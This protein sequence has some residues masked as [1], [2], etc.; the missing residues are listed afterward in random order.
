MARPFTALRDERGFTLVEVMVALFILLVGVAGSVTLID[1]ANGTTLATKAREAGTGLTREVV[2]DARSIPYSSLS[3]ASIQPSLQAQPGLAD[4]NTG[5]SSWTVE[6]RGIVYTVQVS[7][8]AIDDGADGYGDHAD[9]SRYCP[10]GAASASADASADDYKRVLTTVS[11]TVR[12]RTR[13][14]R[15]TTLIPNPSAANGPKITAYSRNPN[16]DPLTDD[17]QQ[18]ISFTVTTDATAAGINWTVDGASAGSYAPTAQTSTFDWTIRDDVAGDYVVDGTYVVGATALDGQGAVGTT[19]SLTIRL[20]RRV[21]AA[22]TGLVGGWNA[23]RSS[24]DLDWRENDESDI[25]GYRVYRR[26]GSGTPAEVCATG[27]TLTTCSDSSPPADL[28]VDYWVVAL[29]ADP[30]TGAGREGGA[31][32]VKTVT[33]TTDRPNAPT[34]LI[35]AAVPSVGTDLVWTPPLPR[36]PSYAGDAILFYRIYRDGTALSA[37]YGRTGAGTDLSFTDTKVSSTARQYWVTAVDSNYSESAAVGPVS[38][39]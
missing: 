10:S 31:S 11:W 9:T 13:S 33:R 20:N 4:S 23:T 34:T 24:V 35:A 6:R 15:Q 36:V 1:G 26:V 2:E 3:P 38:A 32:A 12:A 25:V 22:P 17:A 39:P 29:D 37:R 16:A 21:P 18:A 28:T 8:C 5:D 7:V 19:R 30:S 27:A 14:T